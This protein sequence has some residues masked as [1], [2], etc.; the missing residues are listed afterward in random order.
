MSVLLKWSHINNQELG[1]RYMTSVFCITASSA[2]SLPIL[3]WRNGHGRRWRRHRRCRLH[4]SNVLL[5]FQEGCMPA[6]LL[7]QICCAQIRVIFSEACAFGITAA[8]ASMMTWRYWWP[9]LLIFKASGLKWWLVMSRF[10]VAQH[11][12]I[13]SACNLWYFIG[14]WLQAHDIAAMPNLLR[15]V[16]IEAKLCGSYHVI[17]LKPISARASMYQM[18]SMTRVNDKKAMAASMIFYR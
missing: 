9:W 3:P 10:D 14:A 13:I 15:L 17:W 16:W 4:M 7:G 8:M 2:A 11:I 6:T 18:L 5:I 1:S 12:V